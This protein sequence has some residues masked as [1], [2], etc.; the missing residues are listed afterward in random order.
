MSLP[1]KVAT[2]TP[3][4][5]RAEFLV[6]CVGN[7]ALVEKLLKTLSTTLP[8]DREALAEAV[9]FNDLETV[10]RIAHRLRGTAANV[11]ANPLAQAA[12]QVE[13]VAKTGERITLVYRW[14]SLRNEIDRL[15]SEIEPRGILK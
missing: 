2:T 6:R 7:A 13:Q 11:C 9:E 8:T 5:D 4:I 14:E 3:P 1:I 15:Q 12:Q 10:A